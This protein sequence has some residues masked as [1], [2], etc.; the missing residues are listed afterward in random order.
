VFHSLLKSD[1]LEPRIQTTPGRDNQKKFTMKKTT[2]ISLLMLL[3]SLSA[4][5]SCRWEEMDPTPDDLTL[6]NKKLT[7]EE[8]SKKENDSI[9]AV[10]ELTPDED[11]SL[12]SDPPPK[13]KDQ[14]RYSSVRDF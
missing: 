10:V 4:L 6:A 13:D 14:W 1:N 2:V 9:N 12:P 5:H 7:E 11:D 3:P 8:Y